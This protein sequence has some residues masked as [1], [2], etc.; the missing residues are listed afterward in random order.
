MPVPYK[1]RLVVPGQKRLGAT[2]LEV[3][4]THPSQ[5]FNGF[6]ECQIYYKYKVS[7][8]LRVYY[9]VRRCIVIDD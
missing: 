6:D 4:I 2:D 5:A 7:K 9:N 8:D 1:K 3:P